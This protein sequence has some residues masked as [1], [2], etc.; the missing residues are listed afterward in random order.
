MREG[1]GRAAPAHVPM[2]PH[3]HPRLP[4][5]G[6]PPRRAAGMGTARLAVGGAAGGAGSGRCSRRLIPSEPGRIGAEAT[7][8]QGGGKPEPSPREG[9]GVE[10]GIH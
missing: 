2:Y 1:R 6:E 10:A 5:P 9:G 4:S 3:H 8:G 7:P